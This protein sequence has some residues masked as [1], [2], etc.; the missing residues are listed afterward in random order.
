MIRVLRRVEEWRALRRGAQ[1]SLGFVPTMGALHPGHLS[2][3]ARSQQENDHTLVS[4]FVNSAQFD[5]AQDFERYPRTWEADLALLEGAGVDY[6]F[7][8]SHEELY[9]DAYRYR[10]SE[11]ELSRTLCGAQRPGHFEGMLTVVL[12]LLQIA[13]ADRAYFGEKDYQQYLLVRGMAEAFFLPT[14]IVA[15]PIV[16]EEDGLAMSS[17][18]RRLTPEQRAL[19]PMLARVLREAPSPGEARATLLAQGF[20]V[21]YVE[22]HPDRRFGSVRLGPVRLIDNVRR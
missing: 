19:A 10:L 1:E 21:D 11:T 2:L 17:R 18:N 7:H 4:L 6:V 5:E 9:P 8:P 12:K 16:R 14:E 15:C 20:G 3:V 13:G 22:D